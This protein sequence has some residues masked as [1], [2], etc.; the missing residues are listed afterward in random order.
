M[1]NKTAKYI[2]AVLNFVA[3]VWLALGGV[4]GRA[5]GQTLI[6]KT[7]RL[8]DG[9]DNVYSV[10]GEQDIKERVNVKNYADGNTSDSLVWSG[11]GTDFYLR[12]NRRGNLITV[13]KS[14]GDYTTIQAAVD[15]ATTGTTVLVFPGRYLV[16]SS[17]YVNKPVTI[18]G[19]DKNSCV[20]EIEQIVVGI[21]GKL[22]GVLQLDADGIKL[23]NLTI[24]NIG[25][26][27]GENTT[28]A[29]VAWSGNICISN[30]YIGGNG[31]RDVFCVLGTTNMRCE[32]VI[33]EQYKEASN[34]SHL[35]WVDNN[36]SLQ[37]YGG[38]INVKG[39]GHGAQLNTTKNVGFYYVKFHNAGFMDIAACNNLTIWGCR[40]NTPPYLLTHNYTKLITNFTDYMNAR[41]G[42]DL[43]VVGDI[44]VGGEINITDDATIQGILTA[45]TANIYGSLFVEAGNKDAE[46]KYGTIQFTAN[47]VLQFGYKYEDN[48][49]W[50]INLYRNGAN[51][52][53]TDDAFDANSLKI[54][55]T[56]VINSSGNSVLNA[57]PATAGVSG[58]VV[59]LTAGENL[60]FG[61]VCY[62]K[63]D[64]KYWKAKGSGAE[65]MPAVAMA[66]GT[67]SASAAGSFLLRGYIRNDDW[68]TLT[69]GK[70]VWASTTAG[71][72]TQVKPTGAGE[73]VQ[74]VGFAVGA[75]TIFFD[76]QRVIIT[77]GGEE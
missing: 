2:W 35:L 9:T 43:D 59:T 24:R 53:K 17:I 48:Y 4:G 66:A 75:K 11:V 52:L 72:I 41:I 60:T 71:G 29:V 64:G 14:G 49:T 5:F 19:V 16:E 31:G 32:N 20:V 70:E 58:E 26:T 33:L 15:A 28:P 61:D 38:E 50:D 44:D 30:C 10:F 21:I 23:E 34:A 76:P 1:G 69:I 37:Y 39:T 63:S 25:D 6:G 8:N 3:V 51:I 65:T 42:G 56:E 54:G 67:I 18:I 13:A 12:K 36:A 57:T 47:G 40:I 55:G 62:A 77:L 45:N 73:S 68:D 74:S 22:E 7:V 46:Y 27:T